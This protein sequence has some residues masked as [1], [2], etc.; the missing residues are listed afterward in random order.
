MKVGVVCATRNMAA[1]LGRAMDSVCHQA[2]DVFVVVDD[3]SEDDTPA[4]V[5]HWAS[6]FPFVEYVRHRE[7]TPCHVAALRPVYDSLRVDHVIGLAA[8]DILLPGLVKAIREYAIHAVVFTNYTCSRDSHSWRVSHGY[9]EA[10]TLAPHAVR[11]RLQT[12]VA[13]ETGIGSSVRSDVMQWLWATG[14]HLLGPHADSIGYASAAAMLGAVYLPMDGAHVDFNANGYGQ[15]TA[16]ADPH[17]WA[18]KARR[19]MERAGLDARTAEALI[20]KRCYGFAA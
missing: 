9:A 2:P 12:H 18:L 5:E 3:A 16:A 14:W 8:D 7:K 10:T 11:Q 4:V 19:F 17:G 20:E 6:R 1:T 13:T 15:R